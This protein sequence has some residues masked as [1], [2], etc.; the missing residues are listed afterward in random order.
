MGV[1]MPAAVVVTA[2][3]VKDPAHELS[4]WTCTLFVA[5]LLH[6]VCVLT[7][8]LQDETNRR[9]TSDVVLDCS[10]G[11]L[12]CGVY[13]P[14]ALY[15]SAQRNQ[16][17]LS[18]FLVVMLTI[19]SLFTFVTA[20]SAVCAHFEAQ[21]LCAE[22]AETLVHNASCEVVF[23]GVDYGLA[24]SHVASITRDDCNGLTETATV[25]ARHC[26][27]M[28]T[29][30]V[31]FI[32]VCKASEPGMNTYGADV[33]AEEIAVIQVEGQVL[34]IRAEHVQQLPRV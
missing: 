15:R 33:R 8:A 1:R 32:T 26:L 2:I 30:M 27:A 3:P 28:C 16:Y 31:G 18:R 19:I 34:A 4:K 5:N 7:I 6:F 25:V 10:L 29:S 20:V 21:G 11:F 9:D 17:V 24:H 13:L 23:D 22:C 14:L 12:L